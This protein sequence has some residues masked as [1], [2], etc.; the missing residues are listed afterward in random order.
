MIGSTSCV[1]ASLQG[2]A[3]S[4]DFGQGFLR[5]FA[6]SG[7]AR[8]SV[9]L[10]ARTRFFSFSRQARGL[11]RCLFP[12]VA[13]RAHNDLSPYTNAG[14]REWF[15]RLLGGPTR[16]AGPILWCRRF[17]PARWRVGGL[18]RCS[19]RVGAA[20]TARTISVMRSFFKPAPAP[21]IERIGHGGRGDRLQV[22][23]TA[24]LGSSDCEGRIIIATDE[25]LTGRFGR[26]AHISR[27]GTRC[28][29]SR[30]ARL[31]DGSRQHRS[32]R[33]VVPSMHVYGCDR[34]RGAARRAI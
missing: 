1:G 4:A 25:P 7:R 14:P 11:V 13:A 24:T 26:A 21:T 22:V 32:G 30:R 6:L 28:A 18:L 10:E 2:L 33:H 27:A 17:A 29:R 9:P 34:A 16:F 19:P 15:G 12:S 3:G 5:V 20:A 31:P 8:D 23:R